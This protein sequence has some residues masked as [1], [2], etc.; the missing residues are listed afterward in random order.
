MGPPLPPEELEP[1]L[2]RLRKPFELEEYYEELVSVDPQ[3]KTGT[4]ERRLSQA[5]VWDRLDEVL[6]PSGYV[7]EYDVVST[8]PF[9]VVCRLTIGGITRTGMWEG[10]TIDEA[11]E[12]ALLRAALRFGVARDAYDGGR[13]IVRYVEKVVEPAGGK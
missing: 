2:K 1:L 5:R 9:A 13:T 4:T 12:G 11:Q 7:E 6:T 8:S 3:L 10:E